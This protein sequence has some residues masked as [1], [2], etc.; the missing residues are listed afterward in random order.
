LD[1]PLPDEPPD[2]P[3]EPELDGAGADC[4][5]AGAGADCWGTGADPPDDEEDD[6]VYEGAAE[7]EEPA[8]EE[9]AVLTEWCTV[10]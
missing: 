8:D 6:G 3:P 5:G 7:A 2:E 1:E 9:D 10:W 4:T